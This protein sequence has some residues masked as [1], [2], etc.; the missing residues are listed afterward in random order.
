MS[1]ILSRS[2]AIVDTETDNSSSDT[3]PFYS[4]PWLL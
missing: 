3:D 4:D 1:Q 2:I